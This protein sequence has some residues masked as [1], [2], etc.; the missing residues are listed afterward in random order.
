MGGSHFQSSSDSLR[1]VAIDHVIATPRVSMADGV[2]GSPRGFGPRSPG[3]IP[4]RPA[5]S[6]KENDSPVH[7]ACPRS[8]VAERRHG[9]AKVNGSIP[10]GGSGTGTGSGGAVAVINGPDSAAGEE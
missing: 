4:G 8:S 2:I 9:K 10:F 1:N 7:H 6:H 3:S 5:N